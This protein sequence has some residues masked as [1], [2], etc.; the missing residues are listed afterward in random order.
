[1]EKY[2]LII[3]PN[4]F[5][6][7]EHIEKIVLYDEYKNLIYDGEYNNHIYLDIKKLMIKNALFITYNGE[8][9]FN[10]LW[11]FWGYNEYKNIID[12]MEQ[13]AV[14]YGEYKDWNTEDGSLYVWQKLETALKYYNLLGYKISDCK[15]D[16]YD[17]TDVLNKTIILYD[18]MKDW[19]EKQIL[20]DIEK[21]VI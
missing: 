21:G 7:P 2:F 11:R 12:L 8:L 3:Q 10:M 16:I 14:I 20:K 9:L 6:N 15:V 13:F 17:P 4:N 1:M 5:Y 19:E 18:C